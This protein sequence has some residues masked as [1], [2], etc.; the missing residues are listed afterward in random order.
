MSY[1]YATWSVILAVVWLLV[2]AGVRDRVG[3]HEM[4]I[5]SLLTM[6]LGLTEPIFVPEYW[7]PP[8]LFNLAELT[9]FDLESLVFSFAIGGLASVCY[10]RIFP[11]RHAPIG[12][13][14]HYHLRHRWHRV[15][16][17]S[18]VATFLVL[19]LVNGFNPIYSVI[20]ALFV[21]GLFAGYCRPDLLPKMATSAVIFGLFYLVFF[22][23]LVRV[24]PDYVSQV[25]NLEDI[26][27]VLL[28]GIPIEELLFALSLGFLWSSGYEHVTWTRLVEGPQRSPR[29][30]G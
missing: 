17:V 10:E 23:S 29:K 7:N 14:E 20:I 8:T 27:G 30:P 5:S 28:L 18:P 13:A 1:A 25:W 4:L 2:F 24:Y 6:P 16:L 9:G 26:S 21:G 3:R 19:Y 12:R 15:A 22:L 11:V